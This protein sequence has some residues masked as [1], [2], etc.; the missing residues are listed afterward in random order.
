MKV[1]Y[2]VAPGYT[3]TIPESVILGD[4]EVS[5]TVSAEDVCVKK[6]QKVVIKL[7]DATPTAE[8]EKFKVKT[9]ENAEVEYNISRNSD[10]TKLKTNDVVLEV[11]P[12]NGASGSATLK[13]SAPQNAGYAGE[14]IGNIAFTISVEDV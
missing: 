13:F 8:D 7:T 9:S 2:D 5:K 12:E 14:Y 3:V 11:N 1:T 10:S 6:G 4:T